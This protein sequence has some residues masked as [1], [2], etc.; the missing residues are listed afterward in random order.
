MQTEITEL[1]DTMPWHFHKEISPSSEYARCEEMVDIFKWLMNTMCIHNISPHRFMTQFYEKSV[2]VEDRTKTEIFIQRL[3][4]KEEPIAIFDLD[5]VICDRDEELYRFFRTRYKK[6]DGDLPITQLD[7]KDYAQLKYDFYES[8][9]FT[10]CEPIAEI[11][12]VLNSAPGS[13]PILLLSSRDTK[14]HP[15]L[16]YN[17]LWWL[18]A[19]GISYDGLIFAAEKDKAIL[20][21][22]HPESILFDDDEQ[23]IERMRRICHVY[24]VDPDTRP[25][26]H[27]NVIQSELRSLHKRREVHG[28]K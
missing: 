14:A 1:L 28:F 9:G 26:F 6:S 12:Q 7:P 3:R 20:N 11:V 23:Q 21:W 5:G 27:A 24:H 2:V 25:E 18:T 16:H 10:T 15:R 17:T 13:I 4:K 22:V 19:R 8:G